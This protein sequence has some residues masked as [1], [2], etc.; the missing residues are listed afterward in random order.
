MASKKRKQR[1]HVQERARFFVS[2][3][4]HALTRDS[5]EILIHEAQTDT[6]RVERICELLRDGAMGLRPLAEVYA[7]LRKLVE[8]QPN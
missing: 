1:A 6:K 2:E 3:A 4:H 8:E 7:D 5:L